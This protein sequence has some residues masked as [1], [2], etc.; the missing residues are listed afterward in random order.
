MSM[1]NELLSHLYVGKVTDQF[2]SLNWDDWAR[3]R[4]YSRDSVDRIYDD[5]HEIG[6]VDAASLGPNMEITSPGIIYV[7]TNDL[8]PPALKVRH[9]AIRKAILSELLEARESEGP[10][11]VRDLH[12]LANN[13]DFSREEVFLNLDILRDYYFI[14][15]VGGSLIRLSSSGIE[16]AKK[17]A[18][19][20][21]IEEAWQDLKGKTDEPQAR[22]H[23]LEKLLARILEHEDWPVDLNVRATGEENDLIA[24]QGFIYFVFSCK[25]EKSVVGARVV[26]DLRDRI[27]ARPGS[28][29][30]LVSIGGFSS[31]AVEYVE[32]RLES[33]SILFVS[34]ADLD[35][36]F[37]GEIRIT[38]LISSKRDVLM[39]KRKVVFATDQ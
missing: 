3:E 4:G 13:H 26:R 10:R 5:L 14:E 20:C 32:S 11:N 18:F 29:G 35:M 31:E 6:L 28:I 21:E 25:W 27:T 1:K 17:I 34:K 33:A 37:S 23:E 12:G 24:S 39:K 7:E 8:A 16:L 19:S 36:V 2:H 38:D 22:G 30:V 15:F 9:D